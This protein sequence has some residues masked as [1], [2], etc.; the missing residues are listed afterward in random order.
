MDKKERLIKAFNYLRGEGIVNTQQDVADAMNSTRPNV[1]MALKGEERVLTDKFLTRFCNAFS[2]TFNLEW[3][4]YGKETMLKDHVNDRFVGYKPMACN[5]ETMLNEHTDDSSVTN[6]TMEYEDKTTAYDILNR[7]NEFKKQ[8][9][10]ELQNENKQKQ[11]T[12]EILQQQCESQSVIITQL[13]QTIKLLQRE[14][15]S[16]KSQFSTTYTP[17]HVQP[18]NHDDNNMKDPK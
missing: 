17:F 10:I 14:I 18:V 16:I 9:L 5:K 2:G 8:Q 12:I 3:L 13:T 6:K 4:L 11:R 7:E 1:S 15:D